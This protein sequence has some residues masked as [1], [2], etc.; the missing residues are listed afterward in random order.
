MA[1]E[2]ESE[3]VRLDVAAT[4]GALED[5][6]EGSLRTLVEFDADRF[7]TLYVDE[8]TRSFYRDEEHRHAHF[9]RI[10]SYVNVDL[11]EIDLLTGELFPVADEV[12]YI[13]TALD[14]FTLVRLY[15]D[16]GGLFL[17]LDPGEPV[18]PAV[19]ALRTV[20][21]EA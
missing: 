20:L 10:H 3:I 9:E 14:T 1:V 15:V 12:E 18:E 11:A 21:G 16:D 6:L 19:E 4:L 2:N 13:A 7:N 5:A 17:A 8:E